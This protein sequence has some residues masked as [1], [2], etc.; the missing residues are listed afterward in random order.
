MEH[1]GGEGDRDNY[2]LMR[3]FENYSMITALPPDTQLQDPVISGSIATLTWS[4]SDDTTPAT[5]L[6]YSYRLVRPGPAY[7]AWSTWSSGKTK[8]YTALSP[9]SYKFQ[10]RAKDTDGAIDPSPAS[11]EFA[12]GEAP[13]HAVSTPETPSGPASGQVGEVVCFSSEGA[14]CNQGHAVEYRFDWDDGEFSLWNTSTSAAHTYPSS[15]EYNVRAIARCGQAPGIESEWSQSRSVEVLD[16]PTSP[17]RVHFAYLPTQ[18]K[19]GEP[20]RFVASRLT[21]SPPWTGA[22]TYEWDWDNNGGIDWTTSDSTVRFAFDEGGSHEIRLVATDSTG[23]AAEKTRRLDVSE[24]TIWD[25]IKDVFPW[26]SKPRKLERDE[27]QKIKDFLYIFTWHDD[28]Y[29]DFS[30]WYGDADESVGNFF[31]WQYDWD[32]EDALNTVIDPDISA[33]ITYGDYFLS[34]IAE[35]EFMQSTW[36]LQRYA[37]MY[38]RFFTEVLESA[39]ELNAENIAEAV[40]K[41]LI[42]GLAHAIGKTGS[43]LAAITIGTAMLAPDCRTAGIALKHLAQLLVHNSLYWYLYNRHHFDYDAEEAWLAVTTD[44][45]TAYHIPALASEKQKAVLRAFFERIH[46][47][48]GPYL[49]NLERHIDLVKRDLRLLLKTVVEAHSSV[50]HVIVVPGSPVEVRLVDESGRNTGKVEGVTEAGIPNSTCDE[51]TGEIHVFLPP[52]GFYVE[53]VGTGTGLYDL[54]VVQFEGSLT[55]FSAEAIRIYRGAVHRYHID[56]EVLSKNGMGT[57]VLLDSDGDGVFESFLL[58]GS[59]LDGQDML[60]HPTREG[61]V[62][63]PN[64]VSSAGTAFFYSLPEG[65]STAKLMIFNVTGRLLFETPL[66]VDSTRFPDTGTWDPIDQDGVPLANGPYVY[67]LIADGK[68]IGQG[69]MVIQRE[70]Q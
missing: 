19:V 26:G 40:F 7:D 1:G 35:G 13:S 21:D 50:G 2:P 62:V 10:V 56:W 43:P 48:Y 18:P 27:L 68:V 29:Y 44:G 65:T 49:S 3:P 54:D 23:R 17:I 31:H 39:A 30:S 33:V 55:T 41:T 52:S 32:L 42:K 24:N 51:A 9:G 20:V 11:R 45:T 64:P 5:E 66:D 28:Q 15:G 69:K 46:R 16:N 61:V 60:P 12:I 4:G 14:V 38:T 6:T 58:V 47:D 67:V 37:E 53:V 34:V 25:D 59:D 36:P 63:G 22:V 70:G 8:K 57:E